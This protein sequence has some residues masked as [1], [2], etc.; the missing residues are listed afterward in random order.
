MYSDAKVN[1]GGVNRSFPLLAIFH[2]Q[3]T[4]KNELQLCEA[5]TV[6]EKERHRSSTIVLYLGITKANVT[7]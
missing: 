4:E 5:F 3:R 6:M 7:S 2:C 1:N